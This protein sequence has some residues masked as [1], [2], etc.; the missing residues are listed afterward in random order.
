[1]DN[2]NIIKKIIEDQLEQI[3]KKYNPSR[4]ESIKNRMIEFWN[5]SSGTGR[6]PWVTF[7]FNSE[8]TPE[9]PENISENDKGLIDQLQSIIEHADWNDDYYPA[10]SPGVRQV[11]IPSYFGCI[12][13][14]SSASLRVKPAI[15]DPMDVYKLPVAGFSPETPGGEMLEKMK[16]WRRMTHGLL[17][18]YEADLQGPFSVA[19]Q[20]W[21]IEEFLIAA[22]DSPD[23]VHHLLQRCTEAIIMYGKLMYEASDGDMIP[24]HCMPAIWYPRERGIAVSEDLAA[25]VSPSIVKEFV[26]PYLEQVAKA[27][28]GVFMHSCGSV[29]NVISEL[30]KVEGLVGL[31]F[32]SC[33]TDLKKALSDVD[34]SLFIVSHN[35]PV[36]RIDLPLLSPMQHAELCAQ[37]F[38]E[39]KVNGLCMVM[40]CTWGLNAK[41]HSSAIEK[42]FG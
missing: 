31:N 41:E 42:V 22:Y 2:T 39:N 35:S 11:T 18:L 30:N 19:S 33:E 9:T 24:F 15:K 17:P 21:G 37:T 36:N 10:L 38:T 7:G 29:N 16:Y 32:S 4:V 8:F 23:E 14:F 12:E 5:R 20:I 34:K 26:R 6:I 25:V 1:M 28:G 27:F 40:P 3:Q 13:E